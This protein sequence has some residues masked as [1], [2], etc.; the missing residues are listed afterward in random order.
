MGT[1][2]QDLGG[3]RG[4]KATVPCDCGDSIRKGAP[5]GPPLIS[6]CRKPQDKQH[7]AWERVAA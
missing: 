7:D 3:C 6:D 4:H 5:W 1:A 2:G